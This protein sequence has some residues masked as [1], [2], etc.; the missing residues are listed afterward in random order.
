[1]LILSICLQV[2]VSTGINPLPL[3]DALPIFDIFGFEGVAERT[4]GNRMPHAAEGGK[5]GGPHSLRGRIGGDQIRMRLLKRRQLRHEPRS[6]E[7][8]SELQSR[9]N[10]VCRLLLE[11][12]KKRT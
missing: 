4:H 3:H 10:L 9:E 8:T 12:K 7:D 6:E 1:T 5:R 11:K 2:S